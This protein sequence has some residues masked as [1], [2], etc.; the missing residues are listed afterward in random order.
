M[1]PAEMRRRAKLRPGDLLEV[2]LEEGRVVMERAGV[3]HSL[4]DLARD[5]QRRYAGRDLAAEL[6]EERDR[7]HRKAKG[8][9]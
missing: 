1:I 4:D 3:A 2:R 7:E 8:R 5:V 9:S 6:M